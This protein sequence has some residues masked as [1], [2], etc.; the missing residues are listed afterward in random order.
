MAMLFLS[1]SKPW[2]VSPAQPSAIAASPAPPTRFSNPPAA[3]WKARHI[4][5]IFF[6]PSPFPP[7]HFQSTMSV[8]VGSTAVMRMPSAPTPSGDTAAPAS[9]ATWATGPSAE[10]SLYSCFNIHKS[11]P[12]AVQDPA[13]QHSAL[14]CFKTSAGKRWDDGNWFVH[15]FLGSGRCFLYLLHWTPSFELV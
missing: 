12:A 11:I 2:A 3:H 7:A 6:F 13:V 8:A 1:W 5:S 4:S 10:V 14:L 9:L 15:G